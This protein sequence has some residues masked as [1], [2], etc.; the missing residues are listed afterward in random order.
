M[1]SIKKPLAVQTERAEV[2]HGVAHGVT[3]GVAARPGDTCHARGTHEFQRVLGPDGEEARESQLSLL[4]CAESGRATA[5][6]CHHI[7][8]LSH[9]TRFWRE[10][11]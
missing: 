4:A 5:A 2:A 11:P 7:V 10:R 6:P 9:A 1:E 8:G 3:H